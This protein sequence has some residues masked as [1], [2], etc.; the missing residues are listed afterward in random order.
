M[1]QFVRNVNDRVLKGLC[2]FQV[3]IPKTV[4]VTDVQS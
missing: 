4:R 2:K 3:H 1:T